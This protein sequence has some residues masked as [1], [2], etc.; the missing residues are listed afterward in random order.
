[1][2]QAIAVLAFIPLRSEASE[3]SEMVSQI[4]FGETV[5]VLE[6]KA[7]WSYVKL[8]FDG[9]E[10]WCDTKMLRFCNTAIAPLS[11]IILKRECMVKSAFGELLLSAGSVI[12]GLNSKRDSFCVDGLTFLMESPL[13]K[14]NFLEAEEAIQVLLSLR[15]VPYVWGGRTVWGIDCSGLSQ[16]YG[17]LAN[18]DLPRDASQQVKLG[19]EVMFVQDV[20]AGDLAFFGEDE[21]ITHVGI[22]MQKDVILH[23]SGHVR[24]DKLDQQGIFNQN[25]KGYTHKLRVIKRFTRKD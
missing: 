8:H 2:K 21:K 16:L 3:R 13:S 15:G 14:S 24:T 22:V 25:K 7:G 17:R 1:M 5:D 20:M 4:I 6:E 12:R 18:I 11:G 10:G 9:Y 19:E 23:A